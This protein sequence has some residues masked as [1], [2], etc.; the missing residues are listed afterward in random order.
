MGVF[1]L[2]KDCKIWFKDIT[3]KGAKNEAKLTLDF[4][5]YYFS[6][7]AGLAASRKR[8]VPTAE[9]SELIDYFPGRYH[10]R[11]RVTVALFLARELSGLGVRL[12]DKT[13]AH[14]QISQLISPVSP[15]LLSDLGMKELNHYSAGGF[16]VLTEWFEDRPRQLSSF[17]RI[18]SQR[19]DDAELGRQIIL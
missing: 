11:A 18:F 7:M 15:N 13:V 12:V 3:G 14:K 17:L 16:E 9:T 6:L 2:R 19:I 1:R 10:A 4:D 8:E 5:A